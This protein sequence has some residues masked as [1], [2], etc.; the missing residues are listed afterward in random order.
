M[1]LTTG[2]GERTPLPVNTIY[3]S[4]KS[5][6]GIQVG[7]DTTGTG[8]INNPYFTID[9]AFTVA[10]TSATIALNGDPNAPSIYRHAT[11]LAVNKSI[12]FQPV[13]SYGAT[14]CASTGTVT[15]V[16]SITG[17][18]ATIV[19]GKVIIDAEGF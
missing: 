8:T 14:I 5:Y 11:V 1:I 16:I 15:R 9:K 18:G 10:A 19:F 17:S 3:V 12:T 2:F 7:N 6:G 13:Y 4:N